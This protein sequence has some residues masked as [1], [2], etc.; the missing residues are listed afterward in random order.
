MNL[1]F[2]V[3]NIIA[4]KYLF[5]CIYY[6]LNYLRVAKFFWFVWLFYKQTLKHEV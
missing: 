5:L 2:V 3:L 1:I 6:V 4:C